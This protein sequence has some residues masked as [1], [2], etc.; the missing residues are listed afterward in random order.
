M[1][2][3]KC[4]EMLYKGHLLPEVTIRALCFKF[5]ELLIRES[6]VIHIQ[7][8]VTVVG[9]MH[10]QFHDLLEMFS[11]GGK[12][13]DT[14]YLFLGDYVDR[15]LYS[16]ETIMLLIV[17]KLRYPNRIHLLRGTHASRQL[18]HSYGF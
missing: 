18:T 10:G 15:G 4:L 3:D 7:T 13:P 5:K 17:L 12:V 9:D 14:N 2:L 8:P 6:N 16:I 1:E 11:I